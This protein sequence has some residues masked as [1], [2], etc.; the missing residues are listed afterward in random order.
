MDVLVLGVV[1]HEPHSTH[2]HVGQALELV[3][4]LRPQRTYFT[5]ISHLLDHDDV[6][7]SLPSAVSLAHDGLKVKL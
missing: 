5:H 2:M 4:A 7:A 3:K 1:R 6:N